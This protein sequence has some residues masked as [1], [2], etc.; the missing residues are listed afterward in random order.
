MGPYL[1]I[2]DPHFLNR[3]PYLTCKRR[4]G[5]TGCTPSSASGSASPHLPQV[6]PC[7]ALFDDS[8]SPFDIYGSLFTYYS[9]R[10]PQVPD[11]HAGVADWGAIFAH[12]GA[13]IVNMGP[14]LIIMGASW[15]ITDPY[16]QTRGVYCRA[17]GVHTVKPESLGFDTPVQGAS[18]RGTS[19]IRNTHP[20]RITT[21]PQA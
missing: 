3:S 4:C 8:G 16:L 12:Y 17:Y 21:G 13:L 1:L 5:R 19:L 11:F 7:P 2:T 6:R 14:C 9:L 20:H 15:L 18:Y 10:L